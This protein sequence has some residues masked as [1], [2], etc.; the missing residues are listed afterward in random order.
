MEASS[1]DE[2]VSKAQ[3]HLAMIEKIK[4]AARVAKPTHKGP[5]FSFQEGMDV[6]KDKRPDMFTSKRKAAKVRAEAKRLY[7]KAKR[8]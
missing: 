2:A 6:L 5:T 4:W 8:K 1:V 7:R 3:K